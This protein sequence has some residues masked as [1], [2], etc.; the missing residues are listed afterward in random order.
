MENA[1][2]PKSPEGW[3]LGHPK[4]SEN[5]P[6]TEDHPF[7]DPQKIAEISDEEFMD[8]F[9]GSV[10]FRL[11]RIRLLRNMI[12]AIGNSGNRSF[13]PFLEKTAQARQDLLS[14]YA[15]WA[16]HRMSNRS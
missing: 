15:W 10:F 5:S 8:L 3:N 14:E 12:I 9:Q 4:F 6:G 13:Y 1:G 11:G 7:T 16:L 2:Q